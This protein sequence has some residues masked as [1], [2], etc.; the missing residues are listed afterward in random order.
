MGQWP[1]LLAAQ[2]SPQCIPIGPGR[3]DRSGKAFLVGRRQLRGQLSLHW[4]DVLGDKVKGLLV[5]TAIGLGH[6]LDGLPGTGRRR[7][8]Q[9]AFQGS[10]RLHR[11][12]AALGQAEVLLPQ[13][14]PQLV[15]GLAHRLGLLAI[16]RHRLG[17]AV[18]DDDGQ[19]RVALAQQAIA[20]MDHPWRMSQREPFLARDVLQA[21]VERRACRE[22]GRSN[23]QG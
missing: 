5:S 3:P 1:Q 18:A 22:R 10:G 4:T 15:D 19:L 16:Q 7:L 17:G 11:A 21:N 14:H 13:I 9:H 12:A 23:R 6:P 2:V 20:P 8:V